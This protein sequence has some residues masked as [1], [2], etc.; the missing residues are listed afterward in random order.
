LGR[1]FWEGRPPL[2]YSRLL[3]RF[4]VRPK[5][6]EVVFACLRLRCLATN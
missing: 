5:F 6:G 1:N 2:F 4:T 3:A